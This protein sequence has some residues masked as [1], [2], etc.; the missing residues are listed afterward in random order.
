MAAYTLSTSGMNPAK[1]T[2]SAIPAFSANLCNRSRQ[3]PSPAKSNLA[4]GN[5]LRNSA[6]ARISH[7]CP[8]SGERTPTQ[9]SSGASAGTPHRD[10]ASA[11]CSL[12]GLAG[13]S[14]P[15]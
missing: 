15:S 9:P 1:I 6:S 8:L 10:R 14:I 12:E 11:R 3:G 13:I 5:F 2:A 4:D 7:S